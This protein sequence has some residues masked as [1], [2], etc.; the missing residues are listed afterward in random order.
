M[1]EQQS[2]QQPEHRSEQDEQAIEELAG[3]LFEA[4]RTG[5]AETLGRYVD[6]G[7]PANLANDRGDTLLMLAAYHGHADA[8]RALL[9]RGADPDR[10]N[11]RGQTPLAGAVFK[12]ERE[13]V[14]ALVTAGADPDAG[15]PS[16]RE[17]AR[18]F[19]KEDMLS[20]TGG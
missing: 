12:S 18:M 5:D 15:T 10:A 9:A 13:V 4:A 17:A 3:R 20:A 16:A 11:D 7:L 2:K 19:G 8:V 6:A 1:S 14:A